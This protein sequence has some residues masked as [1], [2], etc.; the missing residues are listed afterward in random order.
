MPKKVNITCRQT[1]AWTCDGTPTSHNRWRS[2]FSLLSFWPG[3]WKPCLHT[4]FWT[5]STTNQ[6]ADFLLAT[7]FTCSLATPHVSVTS[8]NIIQKYLKQ[9]FLF[10]LFLNFLILPQKL[11]VIIFRIRILGLYSLVLGFLLL[12]PDKW[13]WVLI[14]GERIGS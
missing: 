4:I 14:L 13:L 6:Q 5:T 10:T 1:C 2:S 3:S 12:L 7:L 11:A 8:T 9:F